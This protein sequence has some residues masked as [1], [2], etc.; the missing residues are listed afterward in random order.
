MTSILL[1]TMGTTWQIP[2]ELVG[3][4]NPER[5]D[6]YRIHPFQEHIQKTWKENGIDPVDE[7]WIV[8]TTGRVDQDVQKVND[9]HCLLS[10][11]MNLNIW[12]VANSDDLGTEAECSHMKE[13][14]LR[15][16]LHTCEQSRN[17]RLI[18][19]LAGGRKTMSSDMQFSAS[20]F[21]CHALLHGIDHWEFPKQIKTYPPRDFTV[22][23]PKDCSKGITPLVT[24]R[25]TR[26]FLVDMELDNQPLTTIC[27]RKPS[28]NRK[29][30]SLE[31]IRKKRNK[32]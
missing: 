26:N 16:V 13:A 8:T 9:Q 21:G 32:N 3:F 19:S 22:P 28:T 5:V 1:T 15:I 23:I 27:R 14:I 6:L 30:V 18:L 24:G 10:D 20:V 17:G 2:P 25:Y 12:Q 11:P 31:L 7:L 29:P 4:T